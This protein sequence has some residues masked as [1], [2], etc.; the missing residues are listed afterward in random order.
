MKQ[1]IG[2]T[3][4]LRE[5]VNEILAGENKK[6]KKIFAEMTLENFTRLKSMVRKFLAEAEQKKEDAVATHQFYTE[7]AK[8]LEN[9]SPTEEDCI[10]S[11][12]EADIFDAAR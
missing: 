8:A 9:Y 7:L 11:R 5:E 12:L 4:D 2:F 10:E 3:K 6:D 1:I